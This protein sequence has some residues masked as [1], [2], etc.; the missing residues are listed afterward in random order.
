MDTPALSYSAAGLGPV[1]AGGLGVPG[2]ELLVFRYDVTA[3]STST[4]TETPTRHSLVDAAG[5][6]LEIVSRGRVGLSPSEG[7]GVWVGGSERAVGGPPGARPGVLAVT[8]AP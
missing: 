7:G 2:P 1:L 8:T 5:R 3:S 4:T 6:P